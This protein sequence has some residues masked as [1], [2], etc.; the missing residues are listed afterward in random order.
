MSS[1][2]NPETSDLFGG[3]AQ[4]M[5]ERPGITLDEYIDELQRLRAALFAGGGLVVQTWSP[6]RGR[7][8]AL[9]PKVAYKKLIL[10][11]G[12]RHAI[13]Q[14][15]QENYDKPDERGDPI[16]RIG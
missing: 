8:N 13:G 9:L 1:Q 7:H 4:L 10:V 15:W 5:E 11:R 3:P 2:A 16:I 14:F 6:S 12:T